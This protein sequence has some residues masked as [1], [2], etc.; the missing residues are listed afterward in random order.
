MDLAN[1]DLKATINLPK[2][3]FSMKAN[4]PQAGD[5]GRLAAGGRRHLCTNCHES[6]PP[7]LRPPRWSALRER[8]HLHLGT[9]FNKIIK[10]FIV[11]S[12]TMTD[13]DSPTSPAGLHH[14]LPIEF[15]IDQELGPAK[16]RKLS[17]LRKSAAAYSQSTPLSSLQAHGASSSS[18]SASSEVRWNDPYL[19]MRSE[20]QAVNRRPLRRL[21][22][23]RAT[24]SAKV[25]SPSTGVLFAP[26]RASPKQDPV[27]YENHSSPSNFRWFV[28]HCPPTRGQIDP[29]LANH[30]VYGLVWTTTPWDPSRPTWPS[31]NNPQVRIR[32][33]PRQ[34]RRLHRRR[35]CLH[36]LH[37]IAHGRT[38]RSS[39]PSPARESKKPSSA[40][41]SSIAILSAS[42]PTTS[43]WSKAPE[44]SIPRP[45]TGRRTTSS[46]NSTASRLIA[47]QRRK[48]FFPAEGMSSTL[49]EELLK[50]DGLEGNPIVV[51]VLKSHPRAARPEGRPQLSTAG[52]AAQPDH[53]PRATEQWFIETDRNGL[54]ERPRRHQPSNGCRAGAKNASPI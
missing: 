31:P 16:G 30:K 1:L 18:A 52:A 49:P 37:K 17:Q 35:A 4:L 53:L 9:A 24:C 42:S 48:R 15:E 25:S 11:K 32:R 7:P 39:P 50:Q 40:T 33:R 27:E 34:H 23:T 20:Y 5:L 45:A 19:T 26:H 51:R 54:R 29:R 10:D 44:P 21:S 2:T 36:K 12:K 3:S 47:R 41:P 38:P 46:V 22:S 28:S 6:R 8:P 13:F 14:G 43:P